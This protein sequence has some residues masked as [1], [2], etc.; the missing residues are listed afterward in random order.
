MGHSWE[1]IAIRAHSLRLSLM[2]GTIEGTI[3]AT[4][5]FD[6]LKDR[7]RQTKVSYSYRVHGSWEDISLVN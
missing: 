1:A 2:D 4:L 6:F 3:Q 7:L 5:R